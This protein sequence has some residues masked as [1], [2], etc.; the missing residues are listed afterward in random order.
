MDDSEYAAFKTDGSKAKN[1][2]LEGRYTKVEKLEEIKLHNIFDG[3]EVAPKNVAFN[4]AMISSK[5]N[6]MVK[7]GWNL[8]YVTSAVEN[9]AGDVNLNGI[10]ITRLFF[11]K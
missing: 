5:I 7:E 2:E 4:D 8:V 3:F 6:S 1:K 9:D 11:S 10:L